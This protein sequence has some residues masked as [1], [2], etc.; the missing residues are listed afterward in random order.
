VIFGPESTL[1]VACATSEAGLP[2][3]VTKYGP[4]ATLAT[5]TR[6]LPVAVPVDELIVHTPFV[7]RLL[8]VTVHDVSVEENPEPEIETV[9]PIAPE[10]GVNDIV[11]P[12]TVKIPET[13][14]LP[15]VTVTR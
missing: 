9:I 7:T 3:T 4:G 12:I 8:L 11:A 1:N 10:G 6:K 13:L 15:P 2:V 5:L 14:L